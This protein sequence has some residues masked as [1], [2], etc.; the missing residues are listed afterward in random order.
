MA[1]STATQAAL[2]LDGQVVIRLPPTQRVNPEAS[3]WLAAEEPAMRKKPAKRGD[4]PRHPI[5]SMQE[6]FA[7]SLDEIGAGTLA[8]KPKLRTADAPARWEALLDQDKSQGPPA[9]LWRYRPGQS[10]HEL[11]KRMAQ[12]SFGV[13]L[14]L[15][16]MAN[17]SA[18]V[19]AGRRGRGGGGGGGREGAM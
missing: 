7:E 5:P 15:N 2:H 19:G 10:C 11:R 18:R 6:A 9:A 13:Y 4:V 17:S 12:I 14:L 8:L 16:G 1:S 3:T